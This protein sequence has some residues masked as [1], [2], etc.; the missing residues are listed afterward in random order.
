MAAYNPYTLDVS[1][2]QDIGKAKVKGVL[3]FSQ[4]ARAARN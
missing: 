3:A 2:D 4:V 1:L